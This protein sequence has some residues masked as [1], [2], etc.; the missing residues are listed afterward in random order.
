MEVEEEGDEP[1][2]DHP[3]RPQDPPA[4]SSAP[5]QAG[6]AV[7]VHAVEGDADAAEFEWVDDAYTRRTHEKSLAK[8]N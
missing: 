1:Q 8:G 4:D 5:S 3:K 2:P 6:V 7:D